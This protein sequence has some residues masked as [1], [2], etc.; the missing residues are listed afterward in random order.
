MKTVQLADLA[1]VA[2]DI[3]NGE[4]VRIHDGD[5][6]IAEIAPLD[7]QKRQEEH[8]E[9][10]V[11]EGKATRGTGKLPDDFFTRQLP[12]PDASVVAQLID[13]RRDGR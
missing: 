8:I 5:K 4:T 11:R 9:K 12:K 2:E 1:T 3:R 6:A 13:D 10:L 7:A